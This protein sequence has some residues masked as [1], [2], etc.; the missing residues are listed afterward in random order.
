MPDCSQGRQAD[1]YVGKDDGCLVYLRRKSP[2]ETNKTK[3]H[4]TGW[5]VVRSP[6]T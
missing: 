5:A 3:T 4:L 6:L 2:V 1:C